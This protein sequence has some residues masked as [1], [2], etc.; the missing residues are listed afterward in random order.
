MIFLRA[1]QRELANTAVAVFVALFAILI[2]TV[3][4]RLLGQAA[5]GRVPSEAVFALIGFGAIAQLPIVLTLTLFVSVLMTLT[6]SYRDS[7]MVVWFSSGLPLTAWIKPVLRFALPLVLGVGICTLFLSPWAQQKSVE[8]RQRLDTRNDASRV[9]PGVFRESAGATRVF[10]VEVGAA[11]DGRVRNVFVSS[12]TREKRA[13]VVAATG[14][15]SVDPDGS[16]Y[17]V[18]ENGRRYDGK[19]GTPEYQVMQFD[20]YSVK[21]EEK[22]G[23]SPQLQMRA[24]PLTELLHNFSRQAQGEILSRVGIPL[25]ALLLVLLAIPMSYVNPRAG[26]ATNLISAVLVY[27]IY[28]NTISIAQAWVGQGRVAFVPALVVPHLVIL[29]SLAYLFYRRLSVVPL[30]RRLRG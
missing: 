30:W 25:S 6:R 28:S 26:R 24:Q 10:F 5:G 20:R 16:R 13:I 15:L 21:L 2:T 22:E 23:I 29:G 7:E 9:A 8:Y 19:P 14:T 11:E 3:L 27:L 18:L 4:I 17:V 12:E 1:T